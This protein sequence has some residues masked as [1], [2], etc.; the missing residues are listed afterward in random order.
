ME[1]MCLF[2]HV[3]N[4][5]PRLTWLLFSVAPQTSQMSARSVKVNGEEA[6]SVPNVEAI[7]ED[8]QILGK[9]LVKSVEARTEKWSL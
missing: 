4:N 3:P 5:D 7:L 1:P 8:F 6:N 9:G 2:L